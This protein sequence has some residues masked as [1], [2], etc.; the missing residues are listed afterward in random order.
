MDV[1]IAMAT[2]NGAPYLSTQLESLAGQTVKPA[3][4]VV[5]DDGSSD[6]TPELVQRFARTAPFPVI[7]HANPRRLH[8]ADNFL[9]AAGL[10][11]SD[12]IAFCDQDDV[13]RAQKMAAVTR[14]VESSGACLVAHNAAKIDA[15]GRAVGALSHTVT[16]RLLTGADLHPWRF[17]FGFTC[18]FR[19]QLLDVIPA[20]HRPLDLIDPTRQLAHDRWMA[21]LA[22]IYGDIYV[23]EDQLVDYR[24]HGA[25]ASGWMQGRRSLAGSL[26][27]ARH[28]FGYNLLKQLRVTQSLVRLMGSVLSDQSRLTPLPSRRRLIEMLAYWTVFEERCAARYSI[29][30]QDNRD[31]RALQ[32]GRALIN[33][34]YRDAVDGSISY[35]T[36]AQD[37]IVSLVAR[38]GQRDYAEALLSST[39]AGSVAA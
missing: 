28:K 14:A 30:Q 1:S 8:F 27:A 21:F 9:K 16:D 26:N 11:S 39:P 38:P 22:S 15:S 35:R 23:L 7:L 34:A 12:Y 31:L 3:E 20:E 32:L 25:N 33:H 5:C 37:L 17:F 18:T 29:T 19:R 24:Y 2:Y 36:V 6:A 13:W 4:L 10:C